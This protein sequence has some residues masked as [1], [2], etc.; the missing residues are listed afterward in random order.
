M[1]D[2]YVPRYYL[3]GF[4]GEDDRLWVFDRTTG[5]VFPSQ[6]KSV[7]NENGMYGAELEQFLANEIEE[8]AKDAIARMRTGRIPGDDDRLV[9]ARYVA[10]QW[11][12]GPEGRT[13]VANG[14]PTVIGDLREKYTT[15]LRETASTMPD[16]AEIAIRRLAEIHA[17]LDRYDRDR[18]PDIWRAALA[19]TGTESLVVDHL[20]SM[21]WRLL[22]S[23]SLQFITCDNP[24][25]F[26]EHEGVGKVQSEVT[27]PFSDTIVL[28]LNRRPS[29]GQD[30]R[31]KA[32]P[33]AVREINRRMAANASR[34][35]FARR[36]ESW[37]LPLL[38]KQRHHLNRLV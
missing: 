18:P 13:R 14:M 5:Q 28:W 22:V 24:V 21:Q 27:V 16:K 7:A 15:E 4:T 33:A 29:N 26:F 9:L 32:R 37:I 6:P 25:F 3:R 34:F 35:A 23:D 17:V 1:G 36:N 8:P 31:V 20:V 12:R 2:H 38:G 11:K 19:K 30:A 10:M